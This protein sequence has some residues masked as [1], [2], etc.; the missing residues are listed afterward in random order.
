MGRVS[1]PVNRFFEL[2]W[3]KPFQFK[4]P[5]SVGLENEPSLYS[6]LVGFSGLRGQLAVR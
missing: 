2:F 1:F 3:S 5:A 4:I 6:G